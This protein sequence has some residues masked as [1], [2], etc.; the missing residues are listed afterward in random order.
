MNLNVKKDKNVA[1]KWTKLIKQGD[2]Q[3]KVNWYR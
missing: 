1:K 2:N 3:W